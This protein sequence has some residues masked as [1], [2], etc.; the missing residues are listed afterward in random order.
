[1]SQKQQEM[2]EKYLKQAVRS[3]QT[4]LEKEENDPAAQLVGSHLVRL[5][6]ESTQSQLPFEI[7]DSDTLDDDVSVTESVV[8]EE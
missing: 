5:M 1:M 7:S 4:T 8:D 2:K 3:L 6:S